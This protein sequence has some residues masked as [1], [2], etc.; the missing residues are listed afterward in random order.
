MNDAGTFTQSSSPHGLVGREHSSISE[1]SNI[2]IKQRIQIP[3][4]SIT[5]EMLKDIKPSTYHCM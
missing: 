4:Q 3:K 1:I 5:Y 2:N